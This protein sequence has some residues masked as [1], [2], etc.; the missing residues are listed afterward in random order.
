[1]Y[2]KKKKALRRHNTENSKKIFR[3]GIVR[4]P[5]QFSIKVSVSDLYIQDR[6][7]YAL[8]QGKYVDLFREYINRSQTH[9]E[10]GTEAAQFLS[11]NT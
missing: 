6:S 4:P 7:S 3:I 10:I 2:T 5:S 11:G 1:M 9:V 8:L